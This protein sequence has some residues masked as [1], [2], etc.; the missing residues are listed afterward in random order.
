[1]ASGVLQIQPLEL[2]NECFSNLG[3]FWGDWVLTVICWGE[4]LCLLGGKECTIIPFLVIFGDQA[5]MH[6]SSHTNTWRRSWKSSAPHPL[7]SGLREGGR[8]RMAWLIRDSLMTPSGLQGAGGVWNCS[9]EKKTNLGLDDSFRLLV[10]CLWIWGWS[11]LE[12][13]DTAS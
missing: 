8:E 11:W 5:H 2:S 7:S 4:G 1:M 12:P 3:V 6:R 9:P 10:S 13:M